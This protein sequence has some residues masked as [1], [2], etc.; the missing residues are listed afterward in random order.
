[1]QGKRSSLLFISVYLLQKRRRLTLYED[2]QTT[3]KP[4]SASGAIRSCTLKSFSICLLELTR[5]SASCIVHS[6]C[7]AGVSRRSFNVSLQVTQQYMCI[8]M[9]YPFDLENNHSDYISRDLPQDEVVTFFYSPR[10]FPNQEH[11]ECFQTSNLGNQALSLARVPL[12]WLCHIIGRTKDELEVS[13]EHA[14]IN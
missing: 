2:P 1:M 11:N 12:V 3:R 4:S 8:S 9:R 7:S 6:A 5:N 14:S 10:P 13:I